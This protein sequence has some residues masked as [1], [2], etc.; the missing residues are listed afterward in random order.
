MGYNEIIIDI[1]E[2]H[3]EKVIFFN[4]NA[5]ETEFIC[6]FMNGVQREKS[7]LVNIAKKT[8]IPMETNFLS[9]TQYHSPTE[10]NMYSL[11]FERA[12][13]TYKLCNNATNNSWTFD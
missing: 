9:F 12:P 4:M 13:Y 3:L 10:N 2:D 7:F 6:T 5:D 1:S 8:N 11:L